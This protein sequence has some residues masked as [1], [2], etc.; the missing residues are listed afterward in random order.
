MTTL[1]TVGS[2]LDVESI[3]RAL[4][5]AEI[6]PKVNSLDRKE[7]GLQAELSAIGKLKS[8]PTSLDASEALSNERF[9]SA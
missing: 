6:A 7:S 5:D 3:V 2:G 8:S 4:V 1:G 9:R